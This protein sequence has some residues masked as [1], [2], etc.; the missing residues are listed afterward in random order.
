MKTSEQINELAAAL[1]KAQG[2]FLN[3]GRNREVTVKSDKG[4]Y[5]FSYATFDEIINCTRP[6]LAANNLS[7]MQALDGASVTTILMHASGQWIS[8]ELPIKVSEGR[9]AAQAYGS[10]V[11]YAKRYAL[12]AMLGIASEEDDDANAADG[13]VIE[14]SRYK[15]RPVP[16]TP[17]PQAKPPQGASHSA[18]GIDKDT[19]DGAAAAWAEQSIAAMKACRSREELASWWKAN[20]KFI[21]ALETKAP[22]QHERLVVA[23]DD[24]HDSAQSVTGAGAPL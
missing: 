20:A 22:A 18:G 19:R 5:K 9:N 23:Y 21:A 12:T 7:Y 1:S 24:A 10:A 16:P 11:T 6:A 4:S 2:A 13:N 3:P 8:S 14:Q 15:D 17:K